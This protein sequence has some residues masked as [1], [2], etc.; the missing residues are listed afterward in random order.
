[1]SAQHPLSGFPLRSF[2]KLRYADTDRQGHINNAVYATFFETGR[3]ELA[4]RLRQVAADPSRAFVLARIT[5]EYEREIL[6]PGEVEV[7]TRVVSVGRSSLVVE[8]LLVSE[9]LVH[10]RAE[11]VMVLTDTSTRR[12]TPL[13]D[14]ARQT[15]EALSGD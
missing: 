11:S 15:L 4:D 7:G 10:A 6:W 12:S 3:V 9:G 8:Q 2:D 1:M 13:D 5:I 14:N